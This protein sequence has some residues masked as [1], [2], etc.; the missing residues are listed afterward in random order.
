MNDPTEDDDNGV[1]DDDGNWI[2][3]VAENGLPQNFKIYPTPART[4][5]QVSFNARVGETVTI[6]LFGIDGKKVYTRTL[7]VFEE[8]TTFTIPLQDMKNGVYIV[9]LKSNHATQ[10]AKMNIVK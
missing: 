9:E 8:N 10:R 3:R 2:M 5:L 1:I 4:E 6:A 7:Q